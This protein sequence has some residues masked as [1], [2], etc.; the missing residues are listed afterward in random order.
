VLRLQQALWDLTWP[1]RVE[2]KIRDREEF[3]VGI[4][5]PKTTQVVTVHKTRYDIRFPAGSPNGIIDGFAGPGTLTRLDEQCVLLD[6]AVAALRQ[7]VADLSAAGTPTQS[8]GLFSDVYHNA[9]PIFGTSGA[10]TMATV[11]G[12]GGML[13]YKRGLGAFEVHGKIWDTFAPSGIPFWGFPASDEYVK[14]ETFRRSDFENGSLQLN[15]TTGRVDPVDL[16]PEIEQPA[17]F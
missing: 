17:V 13:Y 16:R 8:S 1:W 15:T 5:G 12:E 2:P 6:E 14:H 4:Y 3:V 7:K 9:T 11:N 10:E